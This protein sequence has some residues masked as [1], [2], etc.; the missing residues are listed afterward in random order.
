MQAIKEHE[1]FRLV[2]NHS[3]LLHLMELRGRIDD[4][5]TPTALV[6]SC[7]V[8]QFPCFSVKLC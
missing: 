4:P 5:A 1:E 7:P 3:F 8:V 6:G 2:F